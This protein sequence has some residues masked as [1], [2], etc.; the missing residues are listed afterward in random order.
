MYE[1]QGD[2]GTDLYIVVLDP[3]AFRSKMVLYLT[4]Y[5]G[6]FRDAAPAEP[7]GSAPGSE[8]R[9]HGIGSASTTASSADSSRCAGNWPTFRFDAGGPVEGERGARSTSC[10]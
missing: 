3:A 8:D 4:H 5:F 2:F 10:A 7:T 9:G 6:Q 1:D